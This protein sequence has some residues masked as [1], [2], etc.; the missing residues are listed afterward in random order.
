M[1]KL[2]QKLAKRG[3]MDAVPGYL[4]TFGLIAVF[5]VVLFLLLE[6]LGNQTTDANATHAVNQMRDGGQA[7]VDFAPTWGVVLAIV[8]LLTI[9]IGGFGYMYGRRKGYM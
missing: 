8:V 4:L 9:V 7:I 6:G 5:A 2:M 1:L 3:N